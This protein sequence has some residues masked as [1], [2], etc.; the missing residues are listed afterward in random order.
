MAA[1]EEQTGKRLGAR[2][3]DKQE[4]F[5]ERKVLTLYQFYTKSVVRKVASYVQRWRNKVQREKNVA[6]FAE[7]LERKSRI[8][9]KNK[10]L[11]TI[12][13]QNEDHT[14]DELQEK[15][16]KYQSEYDTAA[17]DLDKFVSESE[18]ESSQMKS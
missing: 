7:I 6:S 10:F 5:Q 13:Q 16:K 14:L 3:K 1:E 11:L 2:L 4:I 18:R 9:L 8:L 15:L 12:N 17:H